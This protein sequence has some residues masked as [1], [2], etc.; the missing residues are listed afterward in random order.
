MLRRGSCGGIGNGISDKM[1]SG[2][3]GGLTKE[4][5]ARLDSIGM[6]WMT[7]PEQQWEKGCAEAAAY[8]K[9]HGNLNVPA[10]YV[11]PTGYKLGSWIADR[12]EK[13]REKHSPERQK[14]L[15]ELG[16]VWV[17]PDP[18]EVRYG[19][20]KEYY[21]EHGNLNIPSKYRAEGIWL[22][23]WVNEQKQI[24]AGKRKGKALREDQVRRLEMIGME[25]GRHRE[26]IQQ[27]IA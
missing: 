1:G 25:W 16:M 11:S 24:F 13:G 7:K 17:K 9:E 3:N 20:A 10:G 26:E 5:I 2:M 27:S 18:W 8:Y 12:R 23:K 4:Q 22:A 15:D 6:I 14:R 21:E 19:L